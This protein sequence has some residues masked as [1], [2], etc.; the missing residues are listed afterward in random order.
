MTE[1]SVETRIGEA[2]ARRHAQQD[3][4]QRLREAWGTLGGDLDGIAQALAA[5]DSALRGVGA[6]TEVRR[7]IG[8]SLDAI[9]RPPY[10]EASPLT[11]LQR[12]VAAT[13]QAIEAVGARV[14]R[15]SVNLGVVGVT[16]SG[17]S[18]LLRRITGLDRRVIPSS[19]YNPTTAA[20]SRIYHRVGSFQAIVHLH[21]WTSFRDF[22]LA[23][24]HRAAA[25]DPVPQT[26]QEFVNRDYSAISTD[27][28]GQPYLTKLRIAH[29]TLP[30]YRRLLDQAGPL[31]LDEN[32][33]RPYVAYPSDGADPTNCPYHAVRSV[34]IF[35][36]FQ[37]LSVARL[38]LVDMPGEGESG[39]DVEQLFIERLRTDVDLLLLLKRPSEMDPFITS[40]DER[41]LRS[42]DAARG[43]VELRDAFR[44]VVNPDLVKTL[45]GHLANAMQKIEERVRDWGIEIYQAD[46]DK[47]DQV[48]RQVLE[49]ALTHLADKLADMDRAAVAAVVSDAERLVAE[50]AAFA[51]DL[52]TQVQ[53]WRAGQPSE[54]T[55]LAKA[56]RD[57]RDEISRDIYE[58]MKNYDRLV[59]DGIVDQDLGAAIAEAVEGSREEIDGGFGKGR[60][61]W[62][63]EIH[64]AIPARRYGAEEQAYIDARGRIAAIFDK[65]DTS[66]E[67]AVRRLWG[68]LAQALRAKLTD[69][70]VPSGDDGQAMLAYLR[71]IAVAREA[72]HLPGAIDELLRLQDNYGSLVLRVTRPRLRQIAINPPPRPAVTGPPGL[73]LAVTGAVADAASSAA[74]V[75]IPASAL[76]N[77]G[78]EWW[79]QN[80]AAAA[81]VA[82]DGDEASRFFDEVRNVVE[83]CVKDLEDALLLEAKLMPRALAAALDRY[84][85]KTCATD[86]TDM[87]YE[88]LCG[89]IRGRVWPGVFDGSAAEVAA[90]LS[91]VA[92][93]ARA[94]LRDV[95]SVRAVGSARHLRPPEQR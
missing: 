87:D 51:G 16:R 6:T 20:P 48:A 72:E 91:T 92:D 45:P 28:A 29:R 5:T 10:G 77:A 78:V 71:D 15:Q 69:D 68:E 9:L 93:R 39:L 79:Q 70:L 57:L 65:I 17:K 55:R 8:G 81:A 59:T 1:L 27:Q 14:S 24:L 19:D 44:V 66:L 33:L 12:R 49:P 22:Y 86:F 73:G 67:H 35:C 82:D 30:S 46:V 90:A 31:T 34:E 64:N 26:L 56:A 75:P 18:T 43:G 76:I 63:R 84:W 62:I 54:A 32:T 42:V 11:Q 74:G 58:L 53:H 60:E 7:R 85:N 41:A 2:L 88:K 89:P 13:A 23:R 52:T 61:Q 38:G 40:Q 4:V 36:P 80:Q 3:Y 83:N 25:V 47:P 37:N 50:V 21:D 94:L 95:E